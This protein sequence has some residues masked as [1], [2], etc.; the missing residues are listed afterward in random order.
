MY[1]QGLG[2]MRYNRLVG[3]KFVFF[4][5]M[6]H[7]TLAIPNALQQLR[8]QL[9]WQMS[10]TRIPFFTSVKRHFS[11]NT[12]LAQGIILQESC[13]HTCGVW[14]W[15]QHP[16]AVHIL[17]QALCTNCLR[18]RVRCHDSG[19]LCSRVFKIVFF[20]LPV[21]CLPT[22]FSCLRMLWEKNTLTAYV[23]LPRCS[24]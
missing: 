17:L 14:H 6:F 13:W 18:A 3:F 2:P 20:V 1:P 12:H 7:P 11:F 8:S 9:V 4:L 10:D 23:W 5:Y 15:P 19:L 22:M 24:C 16:T 21:L